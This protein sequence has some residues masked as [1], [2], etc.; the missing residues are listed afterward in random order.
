MATFQ[1]QIKAC[2][3]KV[4]MSNDKTTLVKIETGDMVAS[5][6][7]KMMGEVNVKV[8]IDQA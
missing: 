4:S 6:L 7:E 8:T 1:G 2:N 5:E 3:V